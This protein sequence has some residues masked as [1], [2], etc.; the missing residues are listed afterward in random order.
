VGYFTLAFRSL[1]LV[2][3]TEYGGSVHG[4]NVL[5]SDLIYPRERPRGR[6]LIEG[7]SQYLCR[8]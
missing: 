3:P 2:C 4:F 8:P 5:Q 7:R 6:L 1:A